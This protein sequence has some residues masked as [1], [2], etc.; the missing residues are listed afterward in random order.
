[1]AEVLLVPG[2]S[3]G[4]GWAICIRTAKAGKYRK[5][6]VAA[7]GLIDELSALG[8]KALAVQADVSCEKDVVRT[9]EEV[10]A[11]LGSLTALVNSA[12]VS[13]THMLVAEFDR[14][15]REQ[16]TQVNVVGTMLCC[17][18]AARRMSTSNGGQGGSIDNVSSMAGTTGGGLA[19][20]HV[21]RRKLRFPIFGQTVTKCSECLVK[22]RSKERCNVGQRA[23]G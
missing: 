7:D 3:R 9:F 1:M 19:T 8:A 12:G 2:G 20:V 15:V 14:E 22:P 6:R 16:L 17:R 5:Q 18:E 23:H 10:S 4:I 13:G 11:K 21:P